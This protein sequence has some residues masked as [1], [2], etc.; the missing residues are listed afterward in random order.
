M[1][2]L[3]WII[4]LAVALIIGSFLNVVI[5]RGPA[6]WGLVEGDA[7]RAGNLAMPGSY[8]PACKAPLKPQHLVPIASYFMLGG[9]CAACNAPINPRYPVVEF[10]A[11]LI[12]ALCIGLFGFSWTALAAT[13][14]G[15]FLL[16]LAVIDLETTYLPDMLTLPLIVLGLG[17]AATNIIPVTLTESCIGAASGYIVFWALGASYKQLRGVDGLGLGDAKLM[18]ALGAWIGWQALPVVVFIGALLTLA[19]VGA[20]A[21]R[22][23]KTTGATEIP[24]GPGLCLAGYVV[25]LTVPYLNIT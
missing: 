23:K 12:A 16:V 14:L 4:A 9:K 1:T 19:F 25:F 20:A 8:C 17:A 24:F 3:L 22:G 2:I 18:A 6:L 13:T 5:H 21:L 10:G 11:L 7:A 15:F